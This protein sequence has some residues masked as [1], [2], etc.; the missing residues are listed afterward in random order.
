MKRLFVAVPVSEEVKHNVKQVVDDL[1]KTGADFKL[2]SLEKAH[3][4]LKFLGDVE[5]EKIPEIKEKL[6]KI[7]GKSKKL[8]ITVKGVGVFPSLE[9]INVVWIGLEDSSLLSLTKGVNKELDYI[10]KNEHGEE[11]PHLTLARV[12]S[13]K[14]KEKVQ[15]LVKKYKDK[16]FSGMVVDKLILYESELTREGPVYTKLAEFKFSG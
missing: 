1:V 13:G 12:K 7:A 8:E 3:F 15:E 16:E 9:K 14:N 2:V 6:Q 5:K 10:N 11:V 4:T